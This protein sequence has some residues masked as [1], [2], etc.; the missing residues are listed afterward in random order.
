MT[1]G[2]TKAYE[3]IFVSPFGKNTEDEATRVLNSIRE[4]HPESNGWVEIEGYVE[5]KADGKWYA[6]RHHEQYK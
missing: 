1:E 5:Q 3:E 4:S 2:K 6:V